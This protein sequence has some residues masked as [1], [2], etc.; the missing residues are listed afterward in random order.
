MFDRVST[1]GLFA[2]QSASTASASAASSSIVWLAWLLLAAVGVAMVMLF[3]TR[4]KD[5]NAIVKCVA[6]SVYVHTVLVI[7]AYGTTLW[8]G[9]WSGNDEPTVR[10][11][12]LSEAELDELLADQSE[13]SGAGESPSRE[14]IAELPAADASSQ[15]VAAQQSSPD[16]DGR[17]D[18]TEDAVAE[19]DPEEPADE[20]PL[21]APSVDR[22]ATE[23]VDV[24]PPP[25]AFD[26]PD[27]QPPN[28]PQRDSESEQ[29]P[30]QL[31]GPTPP[32]YT[33]EDIDPLDPLE[34]TSESEAG[35]LAEGPIE[36]LDPA[37]Q[38]VTSEVRESVEQVTEDP[39]VDRT[40]N[41]R[42]AVRSQA[43]GPTLPPR[44]AGL[45]EP[46]ASVRPVS[47]SSRSTA[48]RPPRYR[49]RTA[50]RQR[51]ALLELLGQDE[52][53]ASV[54]LALQWLQRHQES[55]GSWNPRR[56]GGG[57]ETYTE[58]HNRRGAGV[59]ATTGMTGLALLAFV[60]AGH[61]H[62]Q[63]P[64]QRV[65]ADGIDYLVR[66]QKSD[67]DLSGDASLFA[68]MYCH[69]MASL[70]L[71]ELLAFSGD[72]ALRGPVQRA[73]QYSVRAQDPTTGSW[74][75]AAGDGQ[76][77]MS[78][79]G[80][81]VMLLTT[82]ELSGIE[83]PETT[84]FRM[85]RFVDSMAAGHSGGLSRYQ[86]GRRPSRT[87]TAESL[88]C[89]QFLGMAVPASAER[90]GFDFL[91]QEQ[92]G[93]G[94]VNLYYWYYGSLA[95]LQYRAHGWKPWVEAMESEL[96][97]RQ[98]TTGEDAGSW[99]PDT[100]WGG[101]GGRVYSTA[102]GALCLEVFYRYDPDAA[103]HDIPHWARQNGRWGPVRR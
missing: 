39:L 83:I 90:E 77:D 20:S 30:E 9:S 48:T 25:L 26:P 55:D 37:Q 41:V 14:E 35:E 95:Q 46:L 72:E 93:S 43:G 34:A 84:R 59:H 54:E 80:W 31:P 38:V 57:R 69:G 91:E 1:G 87:M 58:G 67:G 15:E 62:L 23:E 18:L 78:Q 10:V 100:V 6:F 64:Y 24:P 45:R 42:I 13:A 36:S 99:N 19:A 44:A 49:K 70:A 16:D 52:S 27:S 81:Q 7:T 29:A 56:H 33:V 4:W 94:R 3:R 75:Y 47:Q 51:Q 92:P 85:Q 71:A 28:S 50:D 97:R 53:L 96:R 98:R 76:G 73:V 32:S 101:Y 74:R 65:V 89:R 60:G 103:N 102:L 22:A 86:R 79:F 2:D 82:A 21:E 40:P 88:V 11:R 66:Q 17:V 63:G 12:L 68:A 8:M 61:D 5:A